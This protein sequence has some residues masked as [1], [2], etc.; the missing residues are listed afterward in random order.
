MAMALQ[1]Q[2][3]RLKPFKMVALDPEAAPSQVYDFKDGTGAYNTSR[4]TQ[5]CPGTNP[6]S[7]MLGIAAAELCSCYDEGDDD[8]ANKHSAFFPTHDPPLVYDVQIGS[9]PTELVELNPSNWPSDVALS[10]AEVLGKAD[11]ER[12]RMLAEVNP[13]V[14]A[15]GAGNCTDEKVPRDILHGGAARQ[16]CCPTANVKG[17]DVPCAMAFFQAITSSIGVC[18]ARGHPLHVCTCDD[19]ST[20]PK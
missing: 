7:K 5:C 1:L 6:S 10:Y 9:D 19:T 20:S 18:K 17:K 13:T 8:N 12:K 3:Y 2:R 16:P 15:D 14:P 4:C 11:T